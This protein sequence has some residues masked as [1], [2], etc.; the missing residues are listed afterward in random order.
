MENEEWNDEIYNWQIVDDQFARLLGFNAFYDL[1]YASLTFEGNDT[2]LVRSSVSA[3]I[4]R[5][6][7][8][9]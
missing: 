4:E 8:F 7:P 6:H 9:E 5:E 1:R 3:A 2:I